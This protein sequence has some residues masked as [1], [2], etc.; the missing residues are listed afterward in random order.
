MTENDQITLWLGAYHYY[1]GRMTYAVTDFTDLLI[2]EWPQF[3][4]DLQ[5]YI[6]KDLERT[7]VSDDYS[8]KLAATP[9]HPLGMDCDRRQ[10][11]KVRAL[12]ASNAP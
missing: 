5:D 6:R 12:W 4:S 11:E 3:P 7:F 10:W 2:A 9:Y 1:C 8:R